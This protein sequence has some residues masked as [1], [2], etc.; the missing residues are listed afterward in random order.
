M[1]V[2]GR[3]GTLPS[4]SGHALDRGVLRYRGTLGWPLLAAELRSDHRGPKPAP[5]TK[6]R[7]NKGNYAGIPWAAAAGCKCN[8]ARIVCIIEKPWR[9]RDAPES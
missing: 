4:I 9:G 1:G 2:G 3:G 6:A 8:S 7:T 5:Q